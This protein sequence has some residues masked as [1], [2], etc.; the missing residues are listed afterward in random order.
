M[1][2][3]DS[4][5]QVKMMKGALRIESLSVLYKK[6]FRNKETLGHILDYVYFMYS[7]SV[8]NPYRHI[9]PEER[10]ESLVRDLKLFHWKKNPSWKEIEG[11]EGV[12]KLIEDFLL[13]CVT[14]SES[15]MR[16]M[17]SRMEKYRNIM[18]D[19]EIGDPKDEEAMFKAILSMQ[20]IYK[21]YE[22]EVHVEKEKEE[23]KAN[24]R[25]FEV[26]EEQWH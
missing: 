21:T 17:E 7:T 1:L 18:H 14:P 23:W 16:A 4:R 5:G 26:P 10:R 19:T 6:K 15:M 13:Y 3:V 12:E 20:K 25:L 9:F 11:T 8:D 24:M 2:Y 22:K